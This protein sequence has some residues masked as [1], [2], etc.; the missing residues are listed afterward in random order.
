MPSKVKGFIVVGRGS[1]LG[2]ED[3]VSKVKYYSTTVKCY[4]AKASVYAIKIQDFLTLK[5]ED[6]SWR[7]IIEKSLWK[8]KNKLEHPS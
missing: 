8:E 2:E 3:A 5:N 6:G 4:S 1:M 7:G